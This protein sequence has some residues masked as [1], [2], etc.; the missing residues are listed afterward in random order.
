MKE[1]KKRRLVYRQFLISYILIL[2][3]PI[4]LG[5]IVYSKALEII[6]KD[7]KDARMFMLE[8]SRMLVDNY[9]SNVERVA[10]SLSLDPSFQNIVFMDPPAYGSSDIYNVNMAQRAL[11]SYSFSTSFDSNFCVFL[12]QSEI[13]FAYNSTQKTV[14]FGIRE[15]FNNFVQYGDLTYE[16]WYDRVLGQY[17]N[18]SVFPAQDMRASSNWGTP[19][20]CIA[21]IQSIPL[22]YSEPNGA[23]EVLIR[24]DDINRLLSDVDESKSGWTYIL[25]ENGQIITG[26]TNG[27]NEYPNVTLERDKSSEYLH[28]SVNGVNMVVMS[29]KSSYNNWNYVTILPEKTIMTKV[30]YIKT[31]ILIIIL[32]SLAVGLIMSFLLAK[33][34]VKPINEVILTLR[35]FFQ[36]EMEKGR[37]EYDFLKYGVN[38]LINVN[39]DMKATVDDQAMLLK[40]SFLGRLIKGEFNDEVELEMQRKHLEIALEGEWFAAVIVDLKAQHESQNKEQLIEQD[41]YRLMLSRA[42]GTHMD[43]G[44][45]TYF[46]NISQIVVIMSFE[47]KNKL[48]CMERAKSLIAAVREELRASYGID[49]SFYAG[50]PYDRLIDISL[51]YNEAASLLNHFGRETTSGNMVLFWEEKLESSGYFYPLEIEQKLVNMACAG[52]KDEVRR[53]LDTLYQENFQTRMLSSSLEQYLMSDMKGTVMKSAQR[54]EAAK[55]VME[56]F[57][58]KST[59]LQANEIYQMIRTAYE[60]LCDE[61]NERKKSHNSNLTGQLM[62]Y[63]HS[64]YY[65]SDISVSHVASKFKISESY[66]SQFIKEQTGESFSDHVENLRIKHACELLKTRNISIEDIAKLVGYNSAYTFR[67]AFKR[68][69]GVLPTQYNT[70]N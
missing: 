45:Y 46:L 30:N 21:F 13:V 57:S 51:S 44:A 37:S 7:A 6:E 4:T 69:T 63:I 16:E 54:M 12:R 2:V 34:N 27:R 29:L 1:K 5:S 3:L 40:S 53:I 52:N 68:V 48:E 59:R 64:N 61:A 56:L 18:K 36:G 10:I 38:K 25:D 24:T 26:V 49:V 35:S 47:N 58:I 50:V 31:F 65:L 19:T 60:L 43:R 70:G 9:F 62:E 8:Q 15:Y 28:Q 55:G 22:G 20:N 66:L 41:I 67:R 14:H 42:L 11:G 23:V 32:L 33:R 17:H 39:A